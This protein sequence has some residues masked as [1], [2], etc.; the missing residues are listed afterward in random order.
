METVGRRECAPMGCRLWKTV[1]LL[2]LWKGKR[3]S[4]TCCRVTVSLFWA[5]NRVA[6]W[7][8]FFVFHRFFSFDLHILRNVEAN[9]TPFLEC[10]FLFVYC[11]LGRVLRVDI[12]CSNRVECEGKPNS[13]NLSLIIPSL[14]RTACSIDCL[15]WST[16]WYYSH[17]FTHVSVTRSQ[18]VEPTF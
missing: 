11:L 3:K 8:L 4:K 15:C 7:F 18:R 16:N 13:K 6:R 5:E 10:C 14:V 17:I 9:W 2:F 12:G 1:L